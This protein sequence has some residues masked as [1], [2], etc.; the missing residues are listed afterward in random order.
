[1]A[2]FPTAFVGV[3]GSAAFGVVLQEATERVIAIPDV[4]YLA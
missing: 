1:V 4:S 2:Y 3:D